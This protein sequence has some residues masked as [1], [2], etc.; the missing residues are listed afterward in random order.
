LPEAALPPHMAVSL[1]LTVIASL[2]IGGSAASD[3][4]QDKAILR[5]FCCI[6]MAAN[7]FPNRNPVINRGGVQ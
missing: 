5:A 7:F 6:K 1:W 4:L 3:P 2:L